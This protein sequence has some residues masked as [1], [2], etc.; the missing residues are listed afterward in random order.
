MNKRNELFKKALDWLYSKGKVAD[1]RELSLKTEINEVTISRILN[2]KV[3]EP[4]EATLRKLN[5]AF[6]N[7]FN[8][9]YFR[10]DDVPMLKEETEHYQ[11][12]PFIDPASTVNAAIS[13]YI[14]LTNNLT[15]QLKSKEQE[16]TDRLKDKDT[17]IA[18]QIARIGNLEQI[19]EDKKARIAELERQIATYAT[20]D[21]E[22]YPFGIGAADERK[23]RK[24][25]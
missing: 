20:A 3:K 19:L 8:M 23:T 22:H 16:M 25:L 7:I 18:E 6:D 2:D 14:Q 12:E 13:A 10:G 21:I 1:Q 5:A 17:I 9:D 11:P 15:E 24:K 4:S